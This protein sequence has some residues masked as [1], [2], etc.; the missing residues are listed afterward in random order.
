MSEYCCLPWGS[1]VYTPSS[2]TLQAACVTLCF[3]HCALLRTDTACLHA[4]AAPSPLLLQE[5]NCHLQGGLRSTWQ[6]MVTVC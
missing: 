3:G 6:T 4:L 2:S 5:L 1:L